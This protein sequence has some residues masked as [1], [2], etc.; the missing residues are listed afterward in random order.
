MPVT[1]DAGEAML[2]YY[3]CRELLEGL[4]KVGFKY[5]LGHEGSG[6]LWLAQTRGGGYYLGEPRRHECVWFYVC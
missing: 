6:F 4:K 1:L 2:I 5:N 3:S